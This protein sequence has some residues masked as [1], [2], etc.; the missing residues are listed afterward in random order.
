MTMQACRMKGFR[1]YVQHLYRLL[2]N[3][4]EEP[5]SKDNR[6]FLIQSL[7]GQPSI[8]LRNRVSLRNRKSDGVFFTG[9]KLSYRLI[10]DFVWD[11]SSS[12][13]IA[14]VGCGAGDLL[15][16]CAKKLPL[17]SDLNETLKIW[18]QYL[19]GFDI[20]P[21]FIDATKI[22]LVLLA[23]KQGSLIRN[24]YIPALDQIF[25]MI[26]T[27][28]FLSNPEKITNASY[29]VMNPPYNNLQ[30]PA[31]CEWAGGKINAAA[32]FVDTCLSKISAGAKIFAILPDVLRSGSNYAKWR[33][34][35]ER[36]TSPLEI[37]TCGQFDD[38]A[39]VHVFMLKAQKSAE[40][41]KN[42]TIEWIP[43]KNCRKHCVGDYFEVHV[44]AVVPHRDPKKGPRSAYVHAKALPPWKI[45]G[46]FGENRPFSGILFKPPFVLV[47]RTS[48]P[49]EKRAIATIVTSKRKV[50][51]ENHLIVLLPRIKNIDKCKQ[52]LKVLKSSKTDRWLNKRIRCRHLTVGAL[53]D[54][55]WW[56]I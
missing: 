6:R 13:V 43:S 10:N 40:P 56:R 20:H 34:H 18:G 14:D 47:R 3:Q 4:L 36:L 45:L 28:D 8:E 25:P 19:I 46:S 48:R 55:P 37:T 11:S 39:D 17:G 5:N 12:G 50:A 33:K 15:L 49:G 52:L 7:N 23:I 30:A 32:L 31:Y 27:C 2:M 29:I 35:I 44:G 51:V 26:R 53:K 24:S 41:E 38:F 42:K 1:S 22:R 21:E 16:A 54:I 9:S